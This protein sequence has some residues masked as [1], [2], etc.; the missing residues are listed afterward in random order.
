MICD[1]PRS[2][3]VSQV[4]GKTIAY[5]TTVQ[6]VPKNTGGDFYTIREAFILQVKH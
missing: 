2:K 6:P 4:I 1:D 5:K 3:A